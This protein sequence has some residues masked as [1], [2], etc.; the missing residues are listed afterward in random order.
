MVNPIS[1]LLQQNRA[2]ANSTGINL[3]LKGFGEIGSGE[4]GGIT[5]ERLHTFKGMLAFRSPHELYF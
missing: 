1:I 5:K 3:Q 4:H 2:G